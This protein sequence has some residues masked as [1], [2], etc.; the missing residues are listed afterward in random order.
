M[1]KRVHPGQASLRRA[2][3]QESFQR[4]IA[5]REIGRIAPALSTEQAELAWGLGSGRKITRG[6]ADP[7][8]ALLGAF[9]DHY[10]VD[11]EVRASATR[12]LIAAGATR[13][14]LELGVS[15]AAAARPAS[16]KPAPADTPRARSS[17]FMAG[18]ARRAAC[19]HTRRGDLPGA[20]AVSLAS[21]RSCRV[22]A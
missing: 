20:D 9:E 1:L 17:L 16:S 13:K 7:Y 21:L 14:A 8:L 3:L 6:A 22:S 2:G 18:S 15:Q 12:M 4:E 11:A 5:L 10:G 19:R